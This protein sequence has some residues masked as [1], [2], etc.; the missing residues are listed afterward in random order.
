MLLFAV[1]TQAVRAGDD[2]PVKCL[3]ITGDHGHDWKSTTESLKQ[4]LTKDDKVKVDVT[5][6]PTKDLTPEN[7]AKYDVLLLNYRETK[8]SEETK[9]SEDNKKA[10]VDAVKGGKGL[11]VYHF[12]SSAFPDWKEY[13][14][15]IGGGWRT[16]GHHGPKHKFKVK[17]THHKHV[18]S[19]GLDEE[20]EHNIDELYAN[21]KMVDGNVVLATAYSD[22][23][24]EK[25]TGKDEPV[26]WVNTYGKGR[27]YHNSLGHDAEALS[28]PALQEWLRRGVIW[29]GQH[30]P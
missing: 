27:V 4:F 7:L 5:T 6:T 9:W 30:A 25:G 16:Q 26:I 22:P 28:D 10:L 15:L 12:A 21:S 18:V 3:I 24:K 8:P 29:A 19:D 2:Q 14:T 11:V 1:P 13:E 17:K 23:G 20:F